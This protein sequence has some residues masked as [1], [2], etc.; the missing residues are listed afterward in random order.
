MQKIS[1]EK[2]AQLAEKAII[3]IKK[4][5]N[6][7]KN[8]MFVEDIFKGTSAQI[9][10]DVKNII[11]GKFSGQLNENLFVEAQL[12]NYKHLYNYLYEN[13]LLSKYNLVAEYMNYPTAGNLFEWE[14]YDDGTDA[15]LIAQ[16]DA[17]DRTYD[18]S[19]E[20]EY[21]LEK[22]L[23]EIADLHL[24]N[25]N[26]DKAL[27]GK[28]F[29][30]QGFNFMLKSKKSNEKS[31]KVFGVSSAENPKSEIGDLKMFLNKAGEPVSLLIDMDGNEI[32]YDVQ[33]H[34]EKK[35]TDFN[36]LP[37]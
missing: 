20:F 32:H 31:T 11:R 12:P 14:T 9:C 37:F 21:A 26:L 23:K 1:K 18:P 13:N 10:E 15:D 3:E 8:M 6:P 29:K 28:V 34:A 35:E 19:A 25:V 27:N 5:G 4:N 16:M 30:I 7:Y 36:N 2:I 22:L 33:E 17:Y 24:L